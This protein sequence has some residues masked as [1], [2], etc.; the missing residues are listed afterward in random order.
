V[1]NGAYLA[2]GSIYEMGDAGDLLRFGAAR[3]QLWGF[4][5]VFVPLGLYCWNGLGRFFG[6][7]EQAEEVDSKITVLVTVIA[8]LVVGLELLLGGTRVADN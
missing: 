6:F 4:G 3:W 8:A 1:A 7:G 5:F 2:G